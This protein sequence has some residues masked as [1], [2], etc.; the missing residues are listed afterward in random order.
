MLE[1]LQ[2][3]LEDRINDSSV[4]FT[5]NGVFYFFEKSEVVNGVLE[6]KLIEDKEE[7]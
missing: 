7:E 4:V 6:I 1:A 2:I 5:C 3:E